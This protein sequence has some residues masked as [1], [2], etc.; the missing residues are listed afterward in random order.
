MSGDCATRLIRM[1]RSFLL[2]RSGSNKQLPPLG[3]ASHLAHV[4][5]LHSSLFSSPYL[6]CPP[7]IFFRLYRIIHDFVPI[8]HWFHHRYRSQSLIDG[9]TI[10]MMF[11][12]T[13]QG[14][15]VVV[16]KSVSTRYDYH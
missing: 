4:Y 2:R 6:P 5:P 8:G 15:Q 7:M 16:Y 9:K 13:P 14:R 3:W 12:I 1:P 10:T 11:E